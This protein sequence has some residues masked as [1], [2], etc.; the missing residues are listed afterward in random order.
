MIAST[1]RVYGLIGNPIEHSISPQIQNAAYGQMKLDAVYVCFKISCSA[2]QAVS[3]FHRL[4][5]SGI[6]VTI[7]YKTDVIPALDEV[8][9]LAEQVGAVNT[10]KFAERVSGYNTDV[11]ASMRSLREG[12][13][14][15]TGGKTATIVGAGGA[16]RA[17]AFGLAKE[18]CGII[19]SNRTASRASSLRDEIREKTAWTDIEVVPYS[20]G[21]LGGAISRS[22][23]LINATSVG[24]HPKTDESVVTADALH[25]ELTVMDLVYNPPQTKLL[26]QAKGVGCRTA[27]GLSMLVYQAVE[28]IEI[29]T[30]GKAPVDLMLSEARRALREFGSDR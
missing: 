7:P 13:G 27:S 12:L 1:T 30:G 2:A 17:V 22:D 26:R 24:M 15:G 16:A 23:I 14:T 20:T 29:W 9:P 11:S 4:G 19:I 5:V 6:N 3:S 21:E 28:S 18:R 8:D 10:I 25:P